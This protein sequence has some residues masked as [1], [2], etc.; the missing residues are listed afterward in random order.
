MVSSTPV[1]PASREVKKL[2]PPDYPD[3]PYAPWLR[4]VFPA[5]SWRGRELKQI[6]IAFCKAIRASL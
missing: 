5:R 4:I 1:P 2:N 6:G 3:T